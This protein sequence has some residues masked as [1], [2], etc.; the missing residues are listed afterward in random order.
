[1]NRPQVL[2]D[3]IEG[4]Y[5]AFSGYPLPDDTMPCSGCHSADANELLHMAPLRQL[6]WAHLR[7]Y[8]SEALF[9][10]GDLECFKHFLPRIFDLVLSN[11]DWK[12]RIPHPEGVF[13][14]FKYG[15]WKTWPE[16]EQAAIKQLLAAIWEAVRS[17]PPIEGGYIDVDQ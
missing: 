14:K 3:A 9:V 5:V 6:E 2:E 7:K 1:M 13:K 15:E 4:L 10:W 11:P 17:N 8:A 12:D 16:D